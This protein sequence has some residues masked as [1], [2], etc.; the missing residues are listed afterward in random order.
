MLNP[1]PCLRPVAGLLVALAIV[2]G[3]PWSANQ[4]VFAQSQSLYVAVVDANGDPVTDLG[5]D[6]LTVVM[7]GVDSETL[8]L[9]PF[10]W[11]VRLT[12]FV[13]NGE[14]GRTSV[15]QIREGLNAFLD[16][17]PEDVEVA[18]LTTAG[19]PQ[20]VVRYTNDRAEVVSGIDMITPI[21]GSGAT[22]LDA[23][24]EEAKRLDDDDEREYFPVI[25]MVASDGADGSGATPRRYEEALQR[26]VENSATVHTLMLSTAGNQGGIASQ[27]GA[28]VAEVTRGSH[29]S[30]ALGSA[31][32]TMLPELGQEI[33]RKHKLASNQYRLTYE[34][35]DDAS[36][37]PSISIAISRSGLTMV[38]TLDGNV[39]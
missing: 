28:N 21:G 24:V 29:Q 9:E 7:D 16:V 11:P 23:L 3:A 19:R 12:V 17:I 10:N 5:P 31:F 6:E 4:V 20:W 38:P 36:E 25:V 1:H 30:L 37:R 15:G 22:F 2:C 13:D 32:T 33:A 8:N 39:P 27:V 14:G 18:L 26:L 34:P 35:P